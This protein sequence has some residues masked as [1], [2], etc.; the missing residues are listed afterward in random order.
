MDYVDRMKLL[1]RGR[2]VHFVKGR[3]GLRKEDL[4]MKRSY[5]LRK[6]DFVYER[7][8]LFSYIA[9]HLHIFVTKLTNNEMN[10]CLRKEDFCLR[11]EGFIYERKI[12]VG[13][14]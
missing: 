1:F 6:E 11:K 8:V 2:K 9:L 5:C 14:R 4:S 3:F 13:P 10:F 12:F 7:K